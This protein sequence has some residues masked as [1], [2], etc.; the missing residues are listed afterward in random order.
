MKRSGARNARVEA[1]P[2]DEMS[3]RYLD[4]LKRR[5]SDISTVL[6]AS[7]CSTVPDSA[8]RYAATF[9]MSSRVSGFAMPFMIGFLRAPL[10]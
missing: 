1:V 2:A 8:E 5:A 3:A 4:C 7:G 6:N 10:L 9:R